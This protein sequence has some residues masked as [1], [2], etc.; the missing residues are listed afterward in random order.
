MFLLVLAVSYACPVLL[1][2][3]VGDVYIENISSGSLSLK[4]GYL[5]LRVQ[6]VLGL[7]SV[8]RVWVQTSKK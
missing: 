5:K 1:V 4:L 2:Q 8:Q 7:S 3:T 6:K